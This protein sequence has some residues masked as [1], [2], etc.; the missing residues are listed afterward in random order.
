MTDHTTAEHKIFISSIELPVNIIMVRSAVA[1][2]TQVGEIL[3]FE[4]MDRYYLEVA[5]EEA[6]SNAVKHFS[7]GP[8]ADEKITVEFYI[9]EDSLVISIRENGIP[10]DLK[11]ADRYTP[12]SLQGMDAPGLGMLLMHQGMDSVELFVHGRDGKETRLTKKIKYG[13][14]PEGLLQAAV[15]KRSSKRP[16]VKNAVMRIATEE[17]LPEICRLAWRCYGFT[18]EDLL[19]DLDLLKH[20][21]STGELKSVV[22]YDPESGNMVGHFALKY[23]QP[24][25]KVPEIALAFVDPSYKCP[26]L[27][28]KMGQD[29]QRILRES[30]DRGAFD[31]SVT[32]HIFSQKNVQ[33]NLGGSPCSMLMGIAASGM[34]AKVLKTTKQEKG[35]TINHYTPFDFSSHTVYLPSHHEKMIKQIYGWMQLPRDFRKSNTCSISGDSSVMLFPLPDE[36]NVAFIIVNQVG[37]STVAD[38]I[39]SLNQCMEEQKDAV[40]AFLPLGDKALPYLVEQCEKA[41]LS[42][43]GIMPHI[44]NGD[45]R[46]LLQKVM[47]PL[48]TSKIKVYGDRSH[49]LFEYILSE[50]QRVN[51]L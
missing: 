36:L 19:Y 48:D 17:D 16:L 21:H 15:Q 5:V 38:I 50:K 4:K 30:G 35:T 14:I 46:I 31:C 26:G 45:D 25:L 27:T 40:Y 44:H 39:A 12:E 2:A 33:E 22:Y 1:M 24:E 42:F 51:K 28:I 29:I 10:F 6:F 3:S 23:H 49:K 13:V 43:A 32:T 34:Q 11:Q 41:G 47:I 7:R 20:K 18:Q 37:E 9:N 8:G